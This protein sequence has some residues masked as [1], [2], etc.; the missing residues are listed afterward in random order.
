[1][2]GRVPSCTLRHMHMVSLST[3]W[4]RLVPA[5]VVLS[6]ALA[7][8]TAPVAHAETPA[9][10][11]QYTVGNMPGGIAVN[12]AGTIAIVANSSSNNASRIDLSSGT[13]TTITTGA[14]PAWVAIDPAGTYAYVTNNGAN[15]VTRIK[16]SDSTTSVITVGSSPGRIVI[17]PAGTYAYVLIGSPWAGSTADVD[18]ITLSDGTV[19]SGFLQDAT[20]PIVVSADGATIYSY[21]GTGKAFTASTGGAA[22]DTFTVGA[23]SLGITAAGLSADGTALFGIDQ[24]G[25]VRK[26]VISGYT[27]TTFPSRVGWGANDWVTIGQYGWVPGLLDHSLSRIDVSTGEV[28]TV[29]T[30]LNNYPKGI[31]APSDGTFVLVTVGGSAVVDRYSTVSAPNTPP[32]PTAVAGDARAT[33]TATGSGSGATV[34]SL[35]VTATPGGRT[36]TVEGSSGTCDVTLLTNGQAYTFT[37]T[38]TGAGGS[39]SASSASNSV[40]PQAPAPRSESSIPA[41]STPVTFGLILEAGSGRCVTAQ[42]SGVDS[43]AWARL[44]SATDCIRAGYSLTGWSVGAAAPNSPLV[45]KP[46]QQAHVTGDNRLFAVWTPVASTTQAAVP[47]AS[48]PGSAAKPTA[49]KCA[50]KKSRMTKQFLTGKCPAG[51]KRR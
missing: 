35:T 22:A 30:G 17:N 33:V 21:G 8:V 41:T 46:G 9:P 38:A 31:A 27:T 15:T 37:A 50:K 11:A 36:C 23:N 32:A 49:V 34:T 40:T 1:M 16:L 18:R 4:T 48:V 25:D 19:T 42:L 7:L 43:G 13:V 45:L 51:W 20:G 47:A 26:T 39:S 10:A 5:S 12:P 44:P 6:V 24:N 14:S 29:A 28:T 3:P 2:V